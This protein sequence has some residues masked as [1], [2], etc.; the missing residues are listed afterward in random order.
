MRSGGCRTEWEAE[1]VVRSG[2]GT[3]RTQIHRQAFL[4]DSLELWRQWGTIGRDHVLL[5]MMTV[6]YFQPYEET[7]HKKTARVYS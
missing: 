2:W 7:V 3:L 6:K 1:K 5:D 4:W